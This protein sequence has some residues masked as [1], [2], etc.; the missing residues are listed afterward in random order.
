MNLKSMDILAHRLRSFCYHSIEG[1]NYKHKHI[2]EIIKG[3]NDKNYCFSDEIPP[4]IQDHISNLA[5]NN[6]ELPSTIKNYILECVNKLIYY[7]NQ[8]Y[9]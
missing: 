3:I 5:F 1:S 8:F 6:E 9:N 7:N 4:E 2:D